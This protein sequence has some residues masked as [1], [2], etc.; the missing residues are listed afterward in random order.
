MK[1]RNDFVTNS[2]SSS[3]VIAKRKDCTLDDIRQ[4]LNNIRKSVLKFIKS[5]GEYLDWDDM[6]DCLPEFT[7]S[8][9][10]DEK[11]EDALD[12]IINHFARLLYSYSG[13]STSLDDWEVYSEKFSNEGDV[14]SAFIYTYGHEI[15]TDNFKI[16]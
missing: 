11:Y 12:E 5:E 6:D 8:E 3:F 10:R 13:Y 1:I 16:V 4:Y 14:F 7:M 9:I 15:N 2:S